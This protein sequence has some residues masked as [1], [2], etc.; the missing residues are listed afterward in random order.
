M[1]RWVPE[2]PP[3]SSKRSLSRRGPRPPRLV[4]FKSD[5]E[6]QGPGP[7]LSTPAHCHGGGGLARCLQRASPQPFASL[8]T[9]HRSKPFSR[10]R[11]GR[12]WHSPSGSPRA[13][14]RSTK[15]PG[16]GSVSPTRRPTTL[17]THRSPWCS[18][19][20]SSSSATSARKGVRRAPAPARLNPKV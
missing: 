8:R 9:P 1:G 10:T 12:G 16:V 7:F 13:P 14:A 19:K 20:P 18:S 17:S 5:V 4:L 11:V 15:G 6:M 3:P 2:H